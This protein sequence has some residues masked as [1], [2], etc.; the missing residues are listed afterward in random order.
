MLRAALSRNR[1]L[2]TA[3]AIKN[4][5]GPGFDKPCERRSAV[6]NAT[7]RSPAKMKEVQH[8]FQTSKFCNFDAIRVRAGV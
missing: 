5:T 6:V 1:K 2:N 4:R 3:Q 8:N 7:S